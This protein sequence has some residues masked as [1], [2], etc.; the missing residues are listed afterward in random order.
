MLCVLLGAG[1]QN[2][3]EAAGL[4]RDSEAPSHGFTGSDDQAKLGVGGASPC[5]GCAVLTVPEQEAGLGM[6]FLSSHSDPFDMRET[7][8]TVRFFMETLSRNAYVTFY[9]AN[10]FDREHM[11]VPATFLDVPA[12]DAS[13]PVEVSFELSGEDAGVGGAFGIDAVAGGIQR[14]HD[15]DPAAV[16]AVGVLVHS[17]DAEATVYIDEI[18]FSGKSLPNISF[19]KSSDLDPVGVVGLPPPELSWIR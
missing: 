15:Y 10:A 6:N 1:C 4:P 18:S 11:R 14:T 17:G 19:S 13:E 7:T 5:G 8:V 2:D 16:A 3:D 12:A 9:A